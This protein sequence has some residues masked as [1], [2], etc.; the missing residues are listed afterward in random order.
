V[1]VEAQQ[2]DRLKCIW[3]YVHSEQL[4]YRLLERAFDLILSE[5]VCA[6]ESFSA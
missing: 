3:V 6:H 2:H 1:R 4:H 5:P